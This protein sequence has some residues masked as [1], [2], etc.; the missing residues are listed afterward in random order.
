MFTKRLFLS[1]LSAAAVL[2]VSVAAV[3]CDPEE[4]NTD[5][6][7][8]EAVVQADLVGTWR[9][10][11]NSFE[12]KADGK[13]TAT[14]WGEAVSGQWTL[15]GDK[16]TCTPTGGQAWDAKVVL[17][18]GK[19]WLALVYEEGEGDNL[20]RSFE[21]FKKEGATVQS[22]ALTDG[23]WDAPRNGCRPKEYTKA[24]SYT[25][26]MVVKNGKVD[27]Y[28]PAWGFHIQGSF[29]ITNGRM[30]IETDDDHIWQ[31]LYI[32]PDGSFGWNAWGSPLGENDPNWDNSYPAMNAETFAL[33]SPYRWYSISD[34]LKM[35]KKPSQTDP[36]YQ[37]DPFAFQF[38]IYE[39]AENE[40]D[41]ASGLLDFD[42]CVTADGKEAYGG[43][44]GLSPWLYKR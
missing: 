38:R 20:Y 44:V 28:V 6:T 8:D 1:L 16:L 3:S 21:N 34:E 4:D 37:A 12:F 23:R 10:E 30:H 24:T 29:T 43:A 27:L 13:Y 11:E 14:Q 31:G 33:Q 42:I 17:T 22:A 39:W 40:R 7:T 2:A 9:M 35:G 15:D 26:C 32:D 18:G 25:F 41:N 19:A 36:E 5:T